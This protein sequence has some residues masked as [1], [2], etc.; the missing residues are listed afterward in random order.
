[1]IEGL[2]NRLFRGIHGHN[3]VY[4]SC[5]EDPSL[6]REALDLGPRDTVL[7]ITS[8]GC[9]VLDYAL[10]GPAH[11]YAVD[12]NPRQNALLELKLAGIE[13]LDFETFFAVFGRGR[14]LGFPDV[15]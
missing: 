13:S 10:T 2:S 9:N 12:V 1:M 14:F 11:V 4:N 6:D 8:G 3:L 15:Y 7:A 5:W